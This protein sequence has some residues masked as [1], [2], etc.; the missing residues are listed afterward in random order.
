MVYRL[1]GPV[2]CFLSACSGG[3]DRVGM[4]LHAGGIFIDSS[5]AES[6]TSS[7]V[8]GDAFTVDRIAFP[9]VFHVA[10][11]SGKSRLYPVRLVVY[12]SR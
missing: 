4:F 7:M 9:F 1:I 10:H 8:Y 5:F 6:G 2:L 11:F 12:V 3:A